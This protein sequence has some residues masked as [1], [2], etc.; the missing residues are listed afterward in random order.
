MASIDWNHVFVPSV[1]L[2]ELFVR[3]TLMY[4]MIL[5]LLRILAKRN[6]GSLSLQDVLLIMLIADAAQSGMAGDYRSV[7]E[8][9]FLCATIVFWSYALDWLSLRSSRVRKLLEPPPIA[10]VRNGRIQRRNLRREMI[11]QDELMSNLRIHGIEDLRDIK[12]AFLE[13]DGEISVIKEQPAGETE[14]H[15]KKKRVTL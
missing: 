8:G 9:I 14:D 6:L 5:V 2:F 11:S 10:L 15:P 3:G 12:I 13:P 1:P 7:P 4:G